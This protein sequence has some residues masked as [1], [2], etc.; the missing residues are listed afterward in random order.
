MLVVM[1]CC[2]YKKEN[3]G[4]VSVDKVLLSYIVPEATQL[5]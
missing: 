2:F 1:N 5:A 3:L 4:R